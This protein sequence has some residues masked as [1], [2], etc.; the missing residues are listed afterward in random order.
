MLALNNRCAQTRAASG[1]AADGSRKSRPCRLLLEALE[2]RLTPSGFEP[3]REDPQ[4]NPGTLVRDLIASPG[5]GGPGVA[6][7]D[8]DQTNGS[9]QFATAGQNWVPF[10]PASPTSARLLLGDDDTRLRFVPDRNYNGSAA[11]QFRIWD[12]AGSEGGSADT[13]SVPGFGGTFEVA[14]IEVTAVN[15]APFAFSYDVTDARGTSPFDPPGA[16]DGPFSIPIASLTHDAAPGPANENDQ[17][18]LF[19]GVEAIKG[20]TVKVDGANVLFTPD[21]SNPIRSN[22]SPFILYF[23]SF[24]FT[25]RDDGKTASVADPLKATNVVN[26]RIL[27]LA[28]E[29][30]PGG[31]S[32]SS[33]ATFTITLPE[34]VASA[35]NPGSVASG[36]L[37][38]IDP[39]N[40]TQEFSVDNG[41]TWVPFPEQPSQVPQGARTRFAPHAN[42]FGPVTVWF[43]STNNGT[44]DVTEVNDPP[45]AFT[46]ELDSVVEGETRSFTFQ[47]LLG[48]D[49]AG[50]WN[51]RGQGA[52]IESVGDAV[53]GIVQFSDDRKRIEFIAA[54]GFVGQARFRYVINDAGTTAGQFSPLTAT[55]FA[56]LDVLSDNVPPVAVPDAFAT[57]EDEPLTL[58]ADVLLFNDFDP[59]NNRGDDDG[60]DRGGGDTDGG[61]DDGDFRDDDVLILTAVFGATHGTVSLNGGDVV[62]RPEA[63][64]HGP[65]SFFYQISDQRGGFSEAEVSVAVRPAPDDPVAQDD[66]YQ[67]GPG[68][69][70]TA[71]VLLN[72][73]DA[74]GDTLS[75]VLV[76]LPQHGTVTIDASGAVLYVP[77][78]GFSGTD[79]FRYL[80]NDGALDSDVAT[81]T[82]TV[83]AAPVQTPTPILEP[84][85]P[86][87]PEKVPPAPPQPPTQQ[88]RDPTLV[89]PPDDLPS[90]PALPNAPP[91]VVPPSVAVLPAVVRL[92]DALRT[93]FTHGGGDQGQEPAPPSSAAPTT[94][95]ELASSFLPGPAE[96]IRP[97]ESLARP[98]KESFQTGTGEEEDPAAQHLAGPRVASLGESILDDSPDVKHF[99]QALQSNRAGPVSVTIPAAHE[100]ALPDAPAPQETVPVSAAPA[101]PATPGESSF[102]FARLGLAA[103]V[104][105]GVTARV[106]VWLR[107]DRARSPSP[108]G[109]FSRW[110]SRNA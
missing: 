36:S 99:E 103:L 109:F 80:A 43:S 33:N 95:S 26:L 110:F 55:G 3:I 23:A 82:I 97:G 53:G 21:F 7:T 67:T 38:E 51:E 34:D 56:V 76:S 9:W 73:S 27:R 32:G 19:D 25:V 29:A 65:A 8:L 47:Q 5:A 77:E 87:P 39:S 4:S 22:E 6:I 62:F 60:G 45:V 18:L 11:L 24:R 2:D 64:Y 86:A 1:R 75:V 79:T 105:L 17:L 85:P 101:T 44:L 106:G 10:G 68:Q 74:D 30:Q 94:D 48:N 16:A 42:F 93:S 102:P 78:A 50:P 108:K 58:A 12:G 15:D 66:A 91:V 37:P 69:P 13:F 14:T 84:P 35:D 49:R 46:D 72:D 70:L 31:G 92:S 89:P 71:P 104:V 88:G 90:L 63:N 57:N 81:V 61:G 59:N 98:P 54:R 100:E 40:G 107:R 28:P 52:F 83:L 41:V 96:S 20:G